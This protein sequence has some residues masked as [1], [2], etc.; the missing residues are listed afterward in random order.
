MHVTLITGLK[1][2]QKN[3]KERR[4]LQKFGI[5]SCMCECVVFLRFVFFYPIIYFN[6]GFSFIKSI[7]M[8]RSTPMDYPLGIALSFSFTVVIPHII[9]HIL[10]YLDDL[11]AVELLL[12]SVILS[13]T[14]NL[15]RNK[16][17]KTN[18]FLFPIVAASY[19]GVMLQIPTLSRIFG[20]KQ[21]GVS[22]KQF[23][24]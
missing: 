15:T 16:N 7:W 24:Y 5:H 6:Y 22:I 12:T 23:F 20:G 9:V 11:F 4:F 18:L 19:Q 3:F 17:K 2:F 14:H 1:Y 21:G 13:V 8:V 10:S